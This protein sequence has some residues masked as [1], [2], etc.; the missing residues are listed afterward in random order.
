MNPVFSDVFEQVSPWLGV[1]ERERAHREDA[2]DRKSEES[3]YDAV[4]FGLGRF[5]S[6]IARELRQ[7]GHRALG[8]DFDPDLVRRH[9][10]SGYVVRYG[11]AE[12]PEFLATL[13]LK[14][15]R[16]VLSSVR[17]TPVNLALLHGLRDNDY[18]GHVAV[19]AHTTSE[20]EQLEQ[21]GA[22]QVL[23]PYADAAAE[24]VDYLLDAV[25]K[26]P[27]GV[28]DGSNAEDLK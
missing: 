24:A 5:G 23:M 10:G 22:D 3:G 27:P 19:T 6:G 20:A 8:V 28:G 13:P 7:R 2:Q 12:D 16:W 14:Q 11:D 25:G 18:T 15:V 17:D 26:Q 9:E 1:F 4:L 21:A